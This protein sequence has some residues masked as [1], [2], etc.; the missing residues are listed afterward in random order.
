M[1][2]L[3]KSDDVRSGF[4]KLVPLCHLIRGVVKPILS[5]MTLSV[6]LFNLKFPHVWPPLHVSA[7][8]IDWLTVLSVSFVISQCDYFGVS[9]LLES[10]L[11]AR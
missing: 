11:H 10:S 7:L 8:S 2:N 4:K 6:T 3:V 5:I 9:V 1:P